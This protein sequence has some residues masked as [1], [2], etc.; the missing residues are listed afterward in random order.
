[1]IVP[2]PKHGIYLLSSREIFLVNKGGN[3][4][5]SMADESNVSAVSRSEYHVRNAF[6]SATKSFSR[7][8]PGF[9]VGSSQKICLRTYV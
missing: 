7:V 6:M 2:R 1:M 3:S 4:V 5:I 8:Q 9:Q